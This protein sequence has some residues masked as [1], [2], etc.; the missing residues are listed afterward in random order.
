MSSREE[1]REVLE[2]VAEQIRRR[3]LETLAIFTLESVRPLTFLA[4]Q[5]L[6]VIGPLVQPILSLKE[7]DLLCDA[8]EDRG[9]ID[10]LIERLERAEG[11]E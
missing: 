5:A 11:G 7:Y 8:L 3:R 6:I 10:W 4:S 9:N 2:K 1:Q